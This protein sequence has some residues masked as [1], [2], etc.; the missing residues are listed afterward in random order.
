LDEAANRDNKDRISARASRIAAFVIKT[1][2]NIM[3]ARH[4][5]A[6]LQS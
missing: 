1:D 6:L 3:I 5:R 4:A 2:E